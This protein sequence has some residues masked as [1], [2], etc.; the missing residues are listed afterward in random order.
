[1]T[2]KH[3]IALL[4][5]VAAL[6]GC[7]VDVDPGESG[8]FPCKTNDDCRK[9]FVCAATP[10]TDGETRCFEQGELPPDTGCPDGLRTYTFDGV[11]HCEMSC[12]AV[13]PCSG[14]IQWR[15]QGGTSYS[16]DCSV[17]DCT[18]VVPLFY[19]DSGYP[20]EGVCRPD[21]T[22]D[23]QCA[24]YVGHG[25][26]WSPDLVDGPGAETCVPGCDSDPP[27]VR[28]P[29]VFCEHDPDGRHRCIATCTEDAHCAG[30][31][32]AW[33]DGGDDY[34]TFDC[35]PSGCVCVK[36][37]WRSGHSD[38]VCRRACGA[39]PGGQTCLSPAVTETTASSSFCAP[40]AEFSCSLSDC[41]GEKQVC[42]IDEYDWQYPRYCLGTCN[43]DSDC[44]L[45]E[46]AWQD[47][48][49]GFQ[50]GSY[51]ST[52]GDCS[53]IKDERIDRLQ[54][55]IDSGYPG[56]C[57]PTCIEDAECI[58]FTNLGAPHLCEQRTDTTEASVDV[59]VSPC[60]WI[61][62]PDSCEIV[63]GQA[64]CVGG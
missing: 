55:V 57:R 27:S 40:Y 5:P 58:T 54:A 26:L 8:I 47:A 12:T 45:D 61:S 13:S 33:N 53:C 63:S 30:K 4:V 49:G 44:A 14:T 32:A 20:G 29:D 51:C 16:V 48:R 28:C 6:V 41:E 2:G 64:T 42:H 60:A 34:D 1:M 37:H 35:G 3:L 39:C 10:E 46:V 62:C 9:G 52:P 59:C 21:C 43:D 25:C 11:T 36:G 24:A 17:T 23:N 22:E 56:T 15:D 38:G 18:C 7:T 50:K 31:T 19:D